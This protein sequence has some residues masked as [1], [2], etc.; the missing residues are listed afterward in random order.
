MNLWVNHKMLSICKLQSTGPPVVAK[1]SDR[2]LDWS[3]L[4]DLLYYPPSSSWLWREADWCQIIH[5]N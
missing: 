4:D 5:S 1:T 2:Q 3:N